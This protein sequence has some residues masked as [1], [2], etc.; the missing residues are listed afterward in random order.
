MYIYIY[1]NTFLYIYIYIY[2]CLCISLR[3]VWTSR[4]CGFPEIVIKNLGTF[5]LATEAVSNGNAKN[6]K[7]A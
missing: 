6:V 3:S 4:D 5:I 1:M 7:T 2:T